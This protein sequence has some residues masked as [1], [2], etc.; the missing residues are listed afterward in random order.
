MPGYLKKNNADILSQALRKISLSSSISATNPGSV[1]RAITEAITTELGDMYDI[2]DYNLNQNILSTATGAALDLFG[3]LYGVTRKT[4]NDLAII[5]KKLGAFI[6][7]TQ[8]PAPFDI[9]IPSGT[10]VYTDA[11]TYIGRTFSYKTQEETTIL[12]GRKVAYTGLIPNFSDSVF[13]AAPNSLILHDFASPPGAT[14]FCTNPKTISQLINYEEDDSYRARIIKQIRVNASGTVQAVRF[15]ALSVAGVRDISIGQT[16]YGMGSFEA[17]VVPERNVNTKQ[18][19]SQ[20]TAAMES[21]RPLG[22]RM[23]VRLPTTKPVDIS[24]DLII[25]MAG[26]NQIT[27]NAIQRANVGIVRYL[28]SLM[29]GEQLVYNRL[30]STI[31]ESTSIIKD[32]IVKRF[33]INGSELT[34]RNY[35]P[36]YDEQIIPGD[37]VVG[38]ALS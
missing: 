11:T 14:V 32:V 9:K 18:V 8:T 12:M 3:S 25:P 38:V 35:K 6:F 23:F 5:D 36:A 7:F 2:L 37:I 31:L 13:T 20:V 30:I 19:S 27:E 17:I 24:V 1:A 21:V 34:R 29:P 28:N 10:N 33:S 22:T 16:P 26:N 15:A 4:I